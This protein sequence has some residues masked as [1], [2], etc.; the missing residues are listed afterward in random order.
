M[1]NRKRRSDYVVDLI[2]GRMQ[3]ERDSTGKLVEVFVPRK[4]NPY[5][6]ITSLLRDADDTS[7][8]GVLEKEGLIQPYMHIQYAVFKK[9][10]REQ[11]YL[12]K[13]KRIHKKRLMKAGF[14]PKKRLNI[15]EP[16]VLR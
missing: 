5:P 3:K 1:R 7:H 8:Q 11:R 10:P 12:K 13:L 14:D 16:M 9:K 2:S 6:T 4:R 15:S